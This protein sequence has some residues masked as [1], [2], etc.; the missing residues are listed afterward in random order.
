APRGAPRAAG[1]GEPPPQ[2]T[3]KAAG[4]G[5]WWFV[6]NLPV[7]R[8]ANA[9]LSHR[10]GRVA[11]RE[12][13]NPLELPGPPPRPPRLATLTPGTLPRRVQSAPRRRGRAGGARRGAP[14]G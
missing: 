7:E 8:G 10:G 4:G 9:P 1:P 5:P 3:T 13:C 12:G 6:R 2:R 14:R 11:F